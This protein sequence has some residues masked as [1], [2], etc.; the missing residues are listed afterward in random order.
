M[1]LPADSSTTLLGLFGHPVH[2]SLSPSIHNAAFRASGLNWIYLAF[3]VEP[4]GLRRAFEGCRAIQV[5]GLNITIPHKQSVIPLIDELSQEARLIGAVNTV[6]FVEGKA[7]GYNTD[8]RGFI[9]A[10]REEKGFNL[11]GKKVCV[12]GAGGAGRAVAVQAAWEGAG[13]ISIADLEDKKAEDLS[14]LINQRIK[15]DLAL[16]GEIKSPQW[17]ESLSRADLVVDATPLGLEKEDPLSF[18][19]NLLS[20]SALVVDLVYNPPQT[21]LLKEVKKLG[22]GAMNGLG[23]LVHQAALSWEIWTGR[24]APLEVMKEA[25][26]SALR[27]KR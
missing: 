13:Q 1:T 4:S 25:A 27:D 3:E 14:L 11:S 2:H 22:R 16:A 19:P 7:K 9:S 26:R 23:M 18:D 12:I 10:L 8:G 20:S 21:R 17:K 6:H 15:E 24:P 5:V